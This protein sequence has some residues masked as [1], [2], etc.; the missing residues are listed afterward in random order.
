MTT[1][2][3]EP[4]WQRQAREKREAVLNLIPE[5]WR[6]QVPD[7]VDQRDVSGKY[8]DQ[9]L[10]EKEIEITETD[11]EGIVQKTSTGSWTAEEVIRAFAH[12]AALSHQLVRGTVTQ[13]RY[14]AEL[15][16]IGELLARDIL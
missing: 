2:A 15:T 13:W 5:E 1:P 7:V 10:T 14:D 4:A 11:S 6:I 12:R 16:T 9:Y 8:L 3:A